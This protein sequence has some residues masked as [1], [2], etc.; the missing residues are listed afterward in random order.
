MHVSFLGFLHE[1]FMVL[2]SNNSCRMTLS[3]SSNTPAPEETGKSM[4]I[5][6]LW[7]SEIWMIKLRMKI[8]QKSC[9]I[10]MLK[11]CWSC[12]LLVNS[13]F[14]SVSE[15]RENPFLPNGFHDHYPY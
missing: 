9:K 10:A 4:K 6:C 15:N 8:M 2:Q 3:G 5:P 7:Y 13:P 11:S 14:V 1:N 12:I